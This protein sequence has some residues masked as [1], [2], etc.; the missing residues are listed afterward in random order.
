[1]NIGAQLAFPGAI[2]GS[3]VV[4]FFGF[5]VTSNVKAEALPT[6]PPISAPASAA[7]AQLEQPAQTEEQ[8]Q[9][10]TEEDS[11]MTTEELFEAS[12]AYTPA[13]GVEVS[14]SG[15]MECAV[16]D[17]FPP[18]ILQWCEYITT[19]SEN[20]DLP[21]DL[22]AA[23]MLQ[24]SGG[25]PLA[26]SHSGAVGLMQVMPRDGIAEKFMCKNGP[27]F[28]SRPTIA[29]LQDP[30]YNVAYGVKMLSGLVNRF[31]NFRDGLKSYGPMDVGYSYAD[32]VLAIYQRYGK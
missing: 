2:L 16:S 26:Y 10:Q 32:K 28:S 25:Q 31:G 4:A 22:I 12:I 1:M 14:G 20:H 6:P 24:E 17:R 13:E 18:S 29:E 30:E 23:V 21:P 11:G 5:T 19:Y 7:P 8:E 9:L 15:T 27:C 3:L